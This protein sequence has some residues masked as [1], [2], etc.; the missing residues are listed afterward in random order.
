MINFELF[1]ILQLSL[2][3]KNIHFDLPWLM[4]VSKDM[5]DLFKNIQR[6]LTLEGLFNSFN[7]EQLSKLIPE[8]QRLAIDNVPEKIVIG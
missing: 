4:N 1:F 8:I 6:L 7:F 5:A 2:L 3:N